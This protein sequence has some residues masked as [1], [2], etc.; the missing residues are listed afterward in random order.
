MSFIECSLIH[1]QLLL[2]TPKRGCVISSFSSAHF[3]QGLGVLLG[4]SVI[5]SSFPFF[6]EI[7]YFIYICYSLKKKKILSCNKILYSLKFVY[8][9]LSLLIIIKF[10]LFKGGMKAYI[11]DI[12][13][14]LYSTFIPNKNARTKECL[15]KKWKKKSNIRKNFK[16]KKKEN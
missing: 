15:S 5:I 9:V 7:L 3:Q 8:F 6:F 11:D 16:I 12:L 14:K 1:I 2:Y 4:F 13:Y 10:I